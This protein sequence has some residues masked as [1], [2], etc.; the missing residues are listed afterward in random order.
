[1]V[2]SLN[3]LYVVILTK[4]NKYFI[5][6]GDR[7]TYFSIHNHSHYSDIRLKD[8]ISLPEQIIEYANDIGLSGIS[9]SDHESLSGI[10]NFSTGYFK[11]KEE[12]KRSEEHTSELQSRGHLVCRLLLEKKK[13]TN[14]CRKQK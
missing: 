5:Y 7:F 10:V 2:F 3:R 14:K 12:G 13:K 11:M 9:L 4:Y 8:A 1:M 6:R